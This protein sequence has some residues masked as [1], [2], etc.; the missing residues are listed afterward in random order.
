[1]VP[2]KPSMCQ[3]AQCLQIHPESAVFITV[4]VCRLERE[5]RDA[6]C[7][8]IPVTPLG[9]TIAG[10]AV[11]CDIAVSHLVYFVTAF[12]SLYGTEI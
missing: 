2:T 12:V 6:L 3:C 9:T 11:L 4:S 7:T 8:V 1:M 5:R 10:S